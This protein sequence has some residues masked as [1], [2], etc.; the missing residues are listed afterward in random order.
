V[1]SDGQNRLHRKRFR[2]SIKKISN[3]QTRNSSQKIRC[4]LLSQNIQHNLTPPDLRELFHA[5]RMK[6][7]TFHQ[8]H[9]KHLFHRVEI[10]DTQFSSYRLQPNLFLYLS[11]TSIAQQSTVC[12][13]VSCEE[14]EKEMENEMKRSRAYL[15]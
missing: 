13:C 6:F 15:P 12:M 1:F 4:T 7:R 14:R 11:L 5:I 3:R 9:R 2:V 8:K 10:Y